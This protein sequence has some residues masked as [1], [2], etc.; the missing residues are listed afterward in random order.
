MPK[1]VVLR[2][3]DATD[4]QT[5]EVLSCLMFCGTECPAMDES[6]YRQQH[7]LLSDLL[8]GAKLQGYLDVLVQRL[9]VQSIPQLK[10]VKDEDLMEL[11]MTKAE[12][13]RLMKHYRKQT[14]QPGTFSKL[15]KVWSACLPSAFHVGNIWYDS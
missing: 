13:Q 8:A 12:V 2:S 14:A 9:K 5:Y 1:L 3:A 10:Y 4:L 11:G 15:R 7:Q 6:K